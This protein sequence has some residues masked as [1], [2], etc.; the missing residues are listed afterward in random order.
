MEHLLYSLNGLEIAIPMSQL[1]MLLALSTLFV[2]FN[3]YKT[4]VAANFIF[5]LYWVYENSKNSFQNFSSNI[6]TITTT[7]VVVCA[8][9][10][11]LGLLIYY[12][13]V[14]RG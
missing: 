11:G 10:V 9:F 14:E 13:L 7:F 12:Q 5:L 4:T 2:L 8:L 3:K 1:F 6:V